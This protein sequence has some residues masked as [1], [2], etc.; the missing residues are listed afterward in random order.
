MS[1]KK[2]VEWIIKQNASTNSI[3]KGRCYNTQNKFTKW[4][5]LMSKLLF[6][7]K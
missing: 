6:Q 4:T 1:D 3:P 5:F 2:R 7:E